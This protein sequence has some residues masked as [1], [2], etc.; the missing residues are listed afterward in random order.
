MKRIISLFLLIT[1][2]ILSA[3]ALVETKTYSKSS[4]KARRVKV[5]NRYGSVRVEHWN[6]NSAQISVVISVTTDSESRAKEIL[7]HI[8]IDQ[9]EEG[10]LLSSI[11]TTNNMNTRGNEKVDIKYIV[12]LPANYP[13]HVGQKYGSI[14][15][16]STQTDADAVIDIKYGS[17][18]GGSFSQGLTLI[19]GYSNI[20]LDYVNLAKMEIK[21]CKPVKISSAKEVSLD[22]KY[23]DF[24]FQQIDGLEGELSYSGVEASSIKRL[25]MNVRYSGF[26]LNEVLESVK[27]PD[28]SYSN[29]NIEKL[30]PNFSIISVTNIRYSNAKIKM[31][32]KG[33][34]RIE[35]NADKYSSVKLSNAIKSSITSN[36]NAP[37]IEF[38]GKY[39]SLDVK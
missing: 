11:T 6:K 21:Y 16:P 13:I 35:N 39:S 4:D 7:S 17:I 34:L 38:S 2:F 12:T 23:S 18:N 8:N 1:T 29:V 25:K 24:K 19:G 26:N 37:T 22:A 32:G 33:P 3:Q 14:T 15:M 5:E 20:T 10:D 30:S 9:K 36:S 27:L 28:M 31:D